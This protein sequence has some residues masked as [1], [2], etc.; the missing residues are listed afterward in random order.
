MVVQTLFRNAAI[1]IVFIVALVWKNK[2][3]W[4]G[5]GVLNGSWRWQGLMTSE[6]SVDSAVWKKVGPGRPQPDRTDGSM[7][8]THLAN[9]KR[10]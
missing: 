1:N 8:G 4:V 5:L 9:V 10:L 7:C 2:D 6:V 3:L